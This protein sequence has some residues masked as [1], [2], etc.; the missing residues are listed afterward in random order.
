MASNTQPYHALGARPIESGAGLIE[1]PIA[2]ERML[3][4][5]QPV[6]PSPS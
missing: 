5:K 2:I 6:D 3:R 4:K 1:Q